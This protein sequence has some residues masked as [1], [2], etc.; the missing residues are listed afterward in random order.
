MSAEPLLTHRSNRRRLPPPAGRLADRGSVSVLM[1]A[2]AAVVMML[3]LMVGDVGLY[4]AGRARATAAADAAALAAAPVTFHGFG[5]SGSPASEAERFASLNGM[6]VTACECPLDPSWAPPVC[7]GRRGGAGRPDRV[8]TAHR[9]GSG[10]RRVR[11]DP[12]GRRARP[13]RSARDDDPPAPRPVA[14]EVVHRPVDRRR[15]ATGPRR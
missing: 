2:V 6:A 13:P 10:R 11:S 15:P 14:R 1:A 8:R 4:L 3:A 5:S 12:A 9:V 7:F